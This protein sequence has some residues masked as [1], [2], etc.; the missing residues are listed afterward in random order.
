M[1]LALIAVHEVSSL[2]AGCSTEYVLLS[3][4]KALFSLGS[5]IAFCRVFDI[6]LGKGVMWKQLGP[7]LGVCYH[8]GDWCSS[9]E[10]MVSV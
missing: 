7:D 9:A 5:S 1:V 10:I 8:E 3:C 6:L 4:A 2:W